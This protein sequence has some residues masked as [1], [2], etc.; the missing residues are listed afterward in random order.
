M[1]MTLPFYNALLTEVAADTAIGGNS[2]HILFGVLRPFLDDCA[3]VS[4][5]RRATLPESIQKI[6]DIFTSRFGSLQP[7][8]A[9]LKPR[10]A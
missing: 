10:E 1:V 9:Q 7:I 4:Q 2:L 3:V 5:P 8:V 6:V